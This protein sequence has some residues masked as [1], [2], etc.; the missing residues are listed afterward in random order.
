MPRVNLTCANCG[1]GF[2]TRENYLARTETCP[3]CFEF[4]DVTPDEWP[5]DEYNVY[6]AARIQHPPKAGLERNYYRVAAR[7]ERDARWFVEAYNVLKYPVEDEPQKRRRL[8]SLEVDEDGRANTNTHPD[9]VVREIPGD[10]HDGYAVKEFGF[11]SS[12]GDRVE[13]END[14]PRTTDQILNGDED[15]EEDGDDDE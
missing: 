3:T 1:E 6:L 9:I 13:Q 10:S 15:E 4:P 12:H 5:D 7:S 2:E 11:R 14:G 8:A